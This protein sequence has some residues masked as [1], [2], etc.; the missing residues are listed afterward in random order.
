MLYNL[1]CLN[2]N[3][4]HPENEKRDHVG[5]QQDEAC[6]IC[7]SPSKTLGQRTYGGYARISSMSPAEKQQALLKRSKQHSERNT[8]IKERRE[9]LH[10]D[11][12]LD[13]NKKFKQ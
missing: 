13:P 8:D 1:W 5:E 4:E 3:N 11:I 12:G 6:P 9:K 7:G 10:T 2:K